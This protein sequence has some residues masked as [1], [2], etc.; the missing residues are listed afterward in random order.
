MHPPIQPVEELYGARG[1]PGVG[2]PHAKRKAPRSGKQVEQDG[3]L[4]ALG[5]RGEDEAQEEIHDAREGKCSSAPNG[6]G[7]DRGEAAHQVQPLDVKLVRRLK[8]RRRRL[9]PVKHLRRKHSG[10]HTGHDPRDCGVHQALPQRDNV[11]K[12]GTGRIVYGIRILK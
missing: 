11:L 8:S 3:H 5:Q 7:Y 9:Q 10:K 1:D 4:L 2:K 6:Y 12:K